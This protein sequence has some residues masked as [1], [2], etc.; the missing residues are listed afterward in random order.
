MQL[1]LHDFLVKV[2]KRYIKLIIIHH[3]KFQN[4]NFLR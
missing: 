2:I 3:E 1:L 4:V